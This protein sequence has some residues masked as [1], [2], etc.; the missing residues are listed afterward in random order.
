[1]ELNKEIFEKF[2]SNQCTDSEAEEVLAWFKEYPGE[3]EQYIPVDD[4]LADDKTPL[5]ITVSERMLRFIRESYEPVKRANVRRLI[6]RYAVAASLTGILVMAG[7]KLFT[8]STRGTVEPT[9]AS[10]KSTGGAQELKTV[11]NKTKQVMQIR[12]SDSSMATLYPNSS[13]RYLTVFQKDKRDL[14]L[15]GKAQ[16]KVTRNPS[17]PFTV[18]A[19]GIAT[20]VLGTQFLVTEQPNKK[21]SVLL[22]EGMVRVWSQHRD[23][24]GRSVIL[25]PGD[26]VAVTG[27]Q[28][29]NYSWAHNAGKNGNNGLA[30]TNATPNDGSVDAMNN[31]AFKNNKLKD[32]FKKLEEKFGVTINDDKKARGINEKLFTGKFL[33]SDSLDFIVKTI[34][35]WYGLQYR[36]EDSIVTITAK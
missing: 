27:G 6:A 13:L 31:L 8:R 24:S 32:V 7:F 29:S 20:T 22:I 3:L 35:N 9:V 1:M 11:E 14:Y 17:R 12:L 2:L 10:I 34:C 5:N 33:E 36:I 15:K 25:N 26:E 30:K 23:D 18:Y 19:E 16:F 28:F 4:W 21:V